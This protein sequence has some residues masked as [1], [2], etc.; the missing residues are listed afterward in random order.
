MLQDPQSGLPTG[1]RRQSVT[2]TKLWDAASPQIFRALITNEALESVV[3]Q[4]TRSAQQTG[5]M[6]FQTITLTEAKISE[7]RRYIDTARTDQVGDGL[8][9]VSMT[10]RRIAIT[11]DDGSTTV[12]D[13]WTD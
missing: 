11:Y 12:S 13:D 5:Q 8:E 4:F 1:K 10:F 6:T 2:L 3:F 7:L 9:D